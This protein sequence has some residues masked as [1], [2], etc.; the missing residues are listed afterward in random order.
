MLTHFGAAL[1]AAVADE[2]TRP[3]KERVSVM[4]DL[5]ATEAKE[6]ALPN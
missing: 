4:Q 1:K 6:Q 5:P 3:R 2:D